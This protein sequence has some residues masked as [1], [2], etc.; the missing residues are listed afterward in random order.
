MLSIPY[1]YTHICIYSYIFDIYQ[2]FPTKYTL[3]LEQKKPATM[4]ETF[5]M[6]PMNQIG[7]LA[8]VSRDFHDIIL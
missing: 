2:K 7:N 4:S 1:I 3:K 5:D 6:V 8:E